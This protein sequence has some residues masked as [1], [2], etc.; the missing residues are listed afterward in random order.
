MCHMRRRIHAAKLD[1]KGGKRNI[2]IGHSINFNFIREREREREIK[3]EKF[4]DNQE[5]T[6]GR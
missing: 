3:R 2:V 5:V 6:E 1:Q 4:I